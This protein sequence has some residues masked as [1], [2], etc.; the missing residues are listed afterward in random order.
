MTLPKLISKNLKRGTLVDANHYSVINY[1]VIK[2]FHSHK[3]SHYLLD[4]SIL[5]MLTETLRNFSVRISW[6]KFDFSFNSENDYCN[7]D[8]YIKF[9][10]Y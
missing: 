9:I 8:L 5:D 7:Y 3:H 4:Q 1:Y 10:L 6:I 2:F